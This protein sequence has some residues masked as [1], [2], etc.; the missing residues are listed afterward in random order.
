MCSFFIWLL[1]ACARFRYISVISQERL[2]FWACRKMCFRSNE[3]LEMCNYRL[4]SWNLP[5]GFRRKKQLFTWSSFGLHFW[6]PLR[7]PPWGPADILGASGDAVSDPF[8]YPFWYGTGGR[9]QKIRFYLLRPPCSGLF[10]AT[11]IFLDG[12][13][14][15]FGTILTTLTD[16][17]FAVLPRP[18]CA[19]RYLCAS[20]TKCGLLPCHVVQ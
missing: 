9:R 2:L 4:E 17:G 13:G 3:S 16:G 20:I 5:Q 11:G 6:L 1:G 19:G 8:G 7:L 10:C 18:F 14:I 12:F 15:I